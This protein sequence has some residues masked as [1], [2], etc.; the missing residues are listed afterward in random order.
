MEQAVTGGLVGWLRRS[1]LVTRII[2]G[3]V[4]G[5]VL[6]QIAPEVAKGIGVLGSFFVGALKAIAPLLVLV[7]VVAAIANH[8]RGNILLAIL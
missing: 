2:M 1:G 8:Q 5:V 6:A 3:M 7:L 4:L